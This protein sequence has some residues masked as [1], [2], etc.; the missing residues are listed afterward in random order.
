MKIVLERWFDKVMDD[1]NV[2]CPA[3]VVAYHAASGTVDVQPT[4][5]TKGEDGLPVVPPVLHEVPLRSPRTIKA[6]IRMP[7]GVGDLVDLIFT[8]KSLEEHQSGAGIA[9]VFPLSKRR[10]S[11][12][13]C[14]AMPQGETKGNHT[15]SLAEGHLEVILTP[16][17]KLHIGN[18]ADDLTSILSDLLAILKGPVAMG[19]VAFPGTLNLVNQPLGPLDLVELR[20]AQI[21]V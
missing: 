21:L 20:L 10:H 17:T 1:L 6:M 14:Y 9:P 15:P 4:V 18:G 3:T 13:D 12:S 11:L 19:G 7:I 16:G 8:N 2:S 5:G